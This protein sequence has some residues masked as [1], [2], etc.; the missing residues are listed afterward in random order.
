MFVRGYEE[1]ID[2]FVGRKKEEK[3]TAKLIKTKQF[4]N[5]DNGFRYFRWTDKWA[6]RMALYRY[7]V[8][9]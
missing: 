3:Y 8:L 9:A 5:F 1:P 7:V 2:S 4:V 6:N